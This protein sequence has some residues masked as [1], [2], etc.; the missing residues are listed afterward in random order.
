MGDMAD[1]Y[2]DQDELHNWEMSRRGV[3]CLKPQN[4]KN[5]STKNDGSIRVIDMTDTHLQNSI[6]KIRRDNWREEWLEPLLREQKRR[7][8]KSINICQRKH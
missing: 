2:R 6:N 8:L 3:A 5:W 7:K 4:F 1:Y